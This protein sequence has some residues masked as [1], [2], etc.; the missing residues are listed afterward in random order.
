ML[1]QQVTTQRCCAQLVDGTTQNPQPWRC[2]AEFEQHRRGWGCQRLANGRLTGKLLENLSCVCGSSN[3]LPVR[4][5][6]AG[7]AP[8]VSCCPVSSLS[9]PERP[10]KMQ[11]GSG[12]GGER[13]E[14]ELLRRLLHLR[15]S[16]CTS[17]ICPQIARAHWPL[18]DRVLSRHSFATTL[19]AEM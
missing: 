18:R 9:M 5:C 7:L 6:T 4:D 17:T 8:A 12:Q 15:S 16:R 2:C 10:A 11:G 3:G 19:L 14:H 1:P 13:G